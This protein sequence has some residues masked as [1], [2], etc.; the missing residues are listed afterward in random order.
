MVKNHFK[1]IKKGNKLIN[2]NIT[3][4]SERRN[5]PNSWIATLINKKDD[6]QIA[7]RKIKAKKI[8]SLRPKKFNLKNKIVNSLFIRHF[9]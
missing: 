1:K 3:L 9:A 8:K 5:G 4:R 6:P 7:D 2:A